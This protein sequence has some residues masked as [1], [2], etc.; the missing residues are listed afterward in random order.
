MQVMSAS[1][2]S[3]LSSSASMMAFKLLLGPQSTQ[4]VVTDLADTMR[5]GLLEPGIGAA[6]SW[7]FGDFHGTV[8]HAQPLLDHDWITHSR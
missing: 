7:P 5:V 1:T 6:I 8:E 3:S 2:S 4:S